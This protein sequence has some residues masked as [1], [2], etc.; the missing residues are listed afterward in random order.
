MKKDLEIENYE[1]LK[2]YT[3]REGA[4][5]FGVART[6]DL[7]ERHLSLAPPVVKGLDR[8]VS[9]AFHLSDRV[10]EDVVTGPT[11]LYFFHY[12]RVNVLL[13][14]LALKADKFYPK[15]R[16]GRAADPR[17]PDHRLGKTACPYFPQACGPEGRNRLDREE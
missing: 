11:K 16:M 6:A 13:D 3:L 17:I 12:Q 9:M 10:L 1:E 2:N 8:A 4:A 5:L 7:G 15:P 14:E